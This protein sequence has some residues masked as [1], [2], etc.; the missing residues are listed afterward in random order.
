MRKSLQQFLISRDVNGT[1]AQLGQEAK[2]A[3]P[4]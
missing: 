1:A 3:Y 2:K 4:A